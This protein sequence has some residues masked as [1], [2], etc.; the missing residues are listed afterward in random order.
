[1]SAYKTTIFQKLMSG[2]V[3]SMRTIPSAIASTTQVAA[4]PNP[5]EDN[6]SKVSTSVT[7][8]TKIS[9]SGILA[10]SLCVS[11]STAEFQ[12]NVSKL[13]I[14]DSREIWIL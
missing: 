14:A 1:M 2:V 3:H 7:L 8:L 13:N 12:S 11:N 4:Q 5:L 10:D 9:L 6:R